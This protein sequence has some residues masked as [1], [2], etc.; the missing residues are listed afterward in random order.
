MT[1]HEYAL[2]SRL[3]DDIVALRRLGAIV[4][5][6]LFG[7]AAGAAL[8][9][10]AAVHKLDVV[11]TVAEMPSLGSWTQLECTLPGDISWCII[12]HLEDYIRLD[13]P[14]PAPAEMEI[15]F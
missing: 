5:I 6:Q 2:Y 13:A 10:W 14:P 4:S 3:F 1:H 7:A 8:R 11:P 15:P 9:V 12:V